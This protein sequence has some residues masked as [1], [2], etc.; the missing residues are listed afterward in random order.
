M[1]CESRNSNWDIIAEELD[2]IGINIE[3]DNL[4]EIKDAK[5]A[6]IDRLFTR[7]ERYSTIIAGPD[8]L[9]FES[10]DARDL[11]EALDDD[12]KA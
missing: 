7:I 1:S 5:Q 12:F 8:F 2:K 11:I 4:N 10:V 3:D 6:S 9:K